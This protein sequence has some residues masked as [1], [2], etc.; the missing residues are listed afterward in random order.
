MKIKEFEAQTLK[1]CLNQVRQEMGPEAVILE[2]KKKRV[3]GFL[4]FGGKERIQITAALGISV[5]EAPAKKESLRDS[6]P[7]QTPSS[8][9][10]PPIHVMNDKETRDKLNRLE[11]EI[12]SIKEGIQS[13]RLAVNNGM[14]AQQSPAHANSEFPE[15]LNRLVQSDIPESLALEMLGKLP[16]LSAW[17]PQARLPLAEAALREIMCGM[18]KCDGAIRLTPGQTKFVALIGPTG[19]GKTTTIAKLAAHFALVEKK[20][21]GLLTVDTYRIAAV[22][23]LK[24]YS[25]IIDIPVR[26]AYN[27]SDVVPALQTF[28]DSDLVLIDTAGRSQK[29]VMQVKELQSLVEVAKCE[30]HLVLSAS[31]KDMDMKE[32][33]SKFSSVGVHKLIFSKLDETA[34]YGTI[35]TTAT[36]C[37]IP[38]SYIT[39]GQK[40]P[41]DIE[42]ADP[43]RLV[44]IVLGNSL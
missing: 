34:T 12:G 41:E 28:K 36:Q 38:I 5:N 10:P 14:I 24:T 13:I 11:E 27:Q 19:V 26:V 32:Q 2:T 40:V 33:V 7:V 31:T 16:D 43:Q 8:P 42:A 1:E 37:Q 20:R 30:T 9:N 18:I 39:T 6:S 23:Q 35:F 3:G 21:V 4:G 15:L 17:G 25:Q 44:G 29:N 22:D